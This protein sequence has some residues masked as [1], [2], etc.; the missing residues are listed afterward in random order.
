VIGDEVFRSKLRS[1][2][3][4]VGLQRLEF[5]EVLPLRYAVSVLFSSSISPGWESQTSRVVAIV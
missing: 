4:G 3:A 5:I 2:L 1:S